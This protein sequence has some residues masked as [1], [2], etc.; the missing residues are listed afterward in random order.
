MQRRECWY[1]LRSKK[2]GD[3]VPSKCGMRNSRQITAYT[4]INR[5]AFLQSS[6]DCC[7]N[8]LMCIT[9][10]IHHSLRVSVPH[11]KLIK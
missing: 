8:E 5:F 3:G 1:I 7:V 6:R 9:Q 11:L 10:I 2:E 4:D